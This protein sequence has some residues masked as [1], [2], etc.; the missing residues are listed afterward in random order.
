MDANIHAVILILILPL[1]CVFI[2]MKKE[3]WGLRSLASF[4]SRIFNTIINICFRILRVTFVFIISFSLAYLFSFP[5]SCGESNN[6]FSQ[7]WIPALSAGLIAA[8]IQSRKLYLSAAVLITIVAVAL[9]I[10]F[11]ILVLGQPECLWT[12]DPNYILNSCSHPAIAV[13]LWH[14]WLTGIY[15]IRIL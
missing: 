2:W 11:H 14:T 8:F 5:C 13:K 6:P 10:H 7:L 15:G 1:T 9:G 4:H 3:M 12:G